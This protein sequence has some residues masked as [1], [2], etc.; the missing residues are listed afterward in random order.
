MAK[1][2]VSLYI[3][4]TSIRLLVT[5]GKQIREWADLPLKPGL[6]K[7]AVVI[8]EAEVVAKIKLLLKAQKIKAKKVNV[9]VSGLHCLSRS[10][11]LPK[12]PKVMLEIGRASCRERV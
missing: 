10:I 5:C 3:D 4:D 9:G 1:K 6:V 7:N 12:L 8:K 2:I 11:T